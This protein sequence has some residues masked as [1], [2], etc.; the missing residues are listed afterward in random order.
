MASSSEPALWGDEEEDMQGMV[1]GVPRGLF[2]KLELAQ[3]AIGSQG[4]Q[5]IAKALETHPALASLNL[6]GNVFGADAGS[7]LARMLMQNT[8]LTNVELADNSL[9]NSGKALLIQH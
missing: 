3:N 4:T 1:G 5:A 8:V 2:K 6:T 7:A 9:S